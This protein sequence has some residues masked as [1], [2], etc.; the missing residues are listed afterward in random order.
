MTLIEIEIYHINNS[1]AALSI[2]AY[3]AFW[4][5]IDSFWQQFP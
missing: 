2:A 4:V 5:P 3:C 1:V